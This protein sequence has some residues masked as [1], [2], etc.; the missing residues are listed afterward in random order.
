MMAT[1]ARAKTVTRIVRMEEAMVVAPGRDVGCR[2]EFGM[3]QQYK[4]GT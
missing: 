2:L 1:A 3:V 4:K